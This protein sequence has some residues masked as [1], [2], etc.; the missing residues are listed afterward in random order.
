MIDVLAP[1]KVNLGL[2][3]LGRRDDGYHEIRT[4]IVAVSIF[5]RIRLD[6][7]GQ[8]SLQL[9]GAG[10]PLNDN[11]AMRALD[12]LRS[13]AELPPMN[14]SLRKRIP[15]AAGLGGASSDAAAAL[16]AGQRFLPNPVTMTAMH[17]M[18]LSVGSDVPFF[19]DGGPALVSGRGE[20]LRPFDLAHPAHLVVIVPALRIA[21]KT[22][23]MYRA[24]EQA[25]F[26]SGETMIETARR[27][28]AGRALDERHLANVFTRPLYALHPTLLGLLA[29]IERVA[30]RSPAMSGAGPSH[31]L[32]CDDLEEC[33]WL[34]RRLRTVLPASVAR[35][36]PARS[37]RG[38]QMREGIGVPRDD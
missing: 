25:D 1:A 21:D 24:L 6:L 29:R 2:E 33:M 32:L 23:T 12:A 11:L 9:S 7:A 8:S 36:V 17:E 10:A 14:L 30:G 37:V 16:L 5:D 26:T 20:T 13:R 4:V 27:L 38:M 35:V 19:L 15:I 18:A 22:A 34:A 31:Y 3:V 28:E